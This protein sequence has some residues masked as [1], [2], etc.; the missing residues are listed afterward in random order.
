MVKQTLWLI[1]AVL[2]CTSFACAFEQ[3]TPSEQPGAKPRVSTRPRPKE[4]GG[5]SIGAKRKCRNI[6]SDYFE[7]TAVGEG[8]G[9]DA[10]SAAQ[11]AIANYD[12][13]FKLAAQAVVDAARNWAASTNCPNQ[14]KKKGSIVSP[15]DWDHPNVVT[16]VSKSPKE[17]KITIS[18]TVRTWATVLCSE[19]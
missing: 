8:T 2:C 14:C 5:I 9:P 3:R 17:F 15:I 19:E 1:L 4:E 11:A 16:D 7:A 10:V 6:D 13:Q 12:K 18:T